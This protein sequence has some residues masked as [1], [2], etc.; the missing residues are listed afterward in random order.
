MHDDG[1]E[2]CGYWVLH[3]KRRCWPCYLYLHRKGVERPAE[4]IT[5]WWDRKKHGAAA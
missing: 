5:R 1:C 4:A 3:A 2:N